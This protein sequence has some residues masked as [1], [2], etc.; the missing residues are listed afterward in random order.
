MWYMYRVPVQ[1]NIKWTMHNKEQVKWQTIYNRSYEITN[2]VPD[3]WN[4]LAT[5]CYVQYTLMYRY[6]YKGGMSNIRYNII[7]SSV[8]NVWKIIPK[9]F[10][11]AYATRL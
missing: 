8:F 1:Y 6:I 7:F 4:R 11:A 9:K 5:V 3:T 10:K 2:D